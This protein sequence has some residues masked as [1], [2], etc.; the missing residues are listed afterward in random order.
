[1]INKEDLRFNTY[2]FKS[3][4][5]KDFIKY[6]C[7]TFTYTNTVTGIVGLYI[8]EKVFE[9]R[10]EQKAAKYFDSTED[11]AIWNIK[12]VNDANIHSYFEDTE[13][14]ETPIN[15]KINSITLVNEH[16]S[17]SVKGAEY[18]LY[19]TRAI[20]FHLNSKDIYFEKDNVAFSEEIEIKRGHDLVR[21]FP[22]TNDY[23]MS[24]WTEGSI[25]NISTEYITI[26]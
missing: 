16:Q 17:V 24:D 4:I 7:D 9:L 25:P 23:F 11:I 21:D 12:E 26:N 5:G 18:N 10:N 3:M 6:K 20:I 1:M 15:E 14:M 13:Q 19:V 22:K 8:G 2:I